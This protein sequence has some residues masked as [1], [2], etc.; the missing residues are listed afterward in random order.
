MQTLHYTAGRALAFEPFSSWEP[1]TNGWLYLKQHVQGPLKPG[2]NQ[3]FRILDDLLKVALSGPLH[4]T[5]RGGLGGAPPDGGV[6][7]CASFPLGLFN[8][9]GLHSLTQ[10]FSFEVTEYGLIYH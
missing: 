8:F 5:S 1:H 2:Q 6:S 3:A 4:G 10:F 7:L 9:P